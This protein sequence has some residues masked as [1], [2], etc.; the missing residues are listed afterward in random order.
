MRAFHE[1]AEE[2][3]ECRG[4][5]GS[6]ENVADGFGKKDCHGFVLEEVWQ[7]ENQRNQ[8]NELSQAGHK[9][10]DF[11]LTQGNKCLLA[12]VLEAHGET[13]GQEDPHGPGSVIHQRLLIGK[14][15]GKKGGKQ[16]NQQPEKHGVADAHSKLAEE[17]FLHPPQLPGAVVVADKGLSALTDAGEGHGNQLVH[18]GQ[19]GHCPHSHIPAV[20]EQ[21]GSEADG[22]DALCG[23]HHEGGNTQTQ[24]GQD[25]PRDQTH[26]LPA[27]LQ[28]GFAAGEKP[29]DPHRADRLTEHRGSGSSGDSHIQN[30]NQNRIQNDIDNGAN[31][32][33]EHT[34]LGKALGGDKRVH[35]HDHQHKDAAQSI[36]PAVGH[37]VGNGVAAAAEK[38]DQL[39]GKQVEHPGEHHRQKQQHRKAAADNF[40]RL[41]L[42]SPAH[43]NGSQGRAAGTCQHSKGGYQHKNGGKEAHT[44]EGVSADFRN[45]PDVNPIHNVVQQVNDLGHHRGHRKLNHLALDAS[46]AHILFL[47]FC[48]ERSLPGKNYMPIG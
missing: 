29:Q 31:N 37:T 33:G 41:L 19:H 12:A 14:D 4:G 11:C 25:H 7:N 3:E 36:D 28:R 42:V 35:A 34:D 8:Q 23:D 27:K 2:Q 18:G 9:Q 6:G 21:G 10:A 48:H 43:G 38:P 26:V 17:G 22:E 45:M 44:G 32:R 46:G 47:C 40:L 39:R 13:P 20:A 1:P 5:G 24:A 15:P 30:E 16:L